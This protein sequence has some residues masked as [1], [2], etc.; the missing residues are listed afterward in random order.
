MKIIQIITGDK[1]ELYGLDEN[2]MLYRF[3]YSARNWEQYAQNADP[4]PP[5]PPIIPVN[6]VEIPDVPINPVEE[7]PT[8]QENTSEQ[9]TT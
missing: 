9:A 5:P 6:E 2:G 8:T 3:N 1:N 7:T 4:I